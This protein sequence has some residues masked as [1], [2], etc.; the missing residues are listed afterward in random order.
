MWW[1]PHQSSVF[2]LLELIYVHVNMDDYR[3]PRYPPWFSIHSVSGMC[4]FSSRV[5]MGRSAGAKGLQLDA[6]TDSSFCLAW[7]GPDGGLHS[8]LTSFHSLGQDKAH[9]LWLCLLLLVCFVIKRAWVPQHTPTNS[10]FKKFLLV[11]NIQHFHR[12]IQRHSYFYIDLK[13]VLLTTRGWG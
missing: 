2:S 13:W 5:L 3:S 4:S 8:L 11:F 1:T 12:D 9:Q 10:F 6:L 7:R